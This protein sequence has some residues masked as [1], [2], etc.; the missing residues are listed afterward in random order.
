M[1]FKFRPFFIRQAFIHK[2]HPVNDLA[3]TKTFSEML[4]NVKNKDKTIK[5]FR[6]CGK[7]ESFRFMPFPVIN[8]F[9][10]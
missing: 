7:S 3:K 4:F 5:R 9:L 2:H 6:Q 10:E 8:S 1:L